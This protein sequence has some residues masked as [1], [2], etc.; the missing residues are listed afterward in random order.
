[1]TTQEL[2]ELRKKLDEIYTATTKLKASREVLRQEKTAL[3]QQLQAIYSQ[4]MSRDDII[5]FMGELIDIRATIYKKNITKINLLNIFAYPTRHHVEGLPL[6]KKRPLTLEDMNYMTSIRSHIPDR[7]DHVEDADAML[8]PVKTIGEFAYWQC[9]FFGDVL[10]A[11]LPDL[12][13]EC[14]ILYQP[15]DRKTIGEP[16][17]ERRKQVE[18]LVVQMAA[19]DEQITALDADILSLDPLG[20]LMPKAARE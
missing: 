11:K 9:Y 19:I 6:G 7:R 1:M 12:L 5:L 20:R 13:D 10:K 2:S 3:Q 18:A 4:A 16:L 14:E 17:A 8:N 15:D